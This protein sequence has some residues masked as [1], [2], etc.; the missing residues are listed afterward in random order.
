LEKIMSHRLAGFVAVIV[1]GLLPLGNVASAVPAQLSHQ[2]RL[3]DANGK[4][5]S[6]Q[7][8][9]ELF[10]S[11]A[12]TAGNTLHTESFDV[13]LDNGYYSVTLGKETAF[14]AGLFAS[15]DALY[16]GL[17]VDGGDELL[18]RQRLNSVP[19]ALYAD[20]A[21]SLGGG[22][23]DATEVRVNG[24]TV[25]NSNGAWAGAAPP[26][27]LP[28]V[29]CSPNDVL[30]FAGGQWVCSDPSSLVTGPLA[31]ATGGGNVPFACRRASATN[32]NNVTCATGEFVIGGG[33]SCAFG[34]YHLSSSQPLLTTPPGW[35]VGCHDPV[36]NTAQTPMV[37]YAFCCK[38]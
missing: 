13:T 3:F 1:V 16:L 24:A 17:R 22:V 37:V 10:I 28:T 30:H 29:T 31:L 19:Y 26:G 6:G 32:A 20:T 4:A 25:V 2:G 7:H 38:S 5:L 9:L 27:T 23:V 12:A 11:D 34:Q 21:T 35:Q 18:P 8:T 15:S 33:G 36:S 14:A